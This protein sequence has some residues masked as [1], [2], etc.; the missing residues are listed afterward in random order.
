MPFTYT[1]DATFE[2]KPDDNNY[3]YEVDNYIRAL[4][5]AIRERMEVDHI[6]K[7][8]ATDGGHNKVS[9]A[10]QATKPTAVAGYGY[11]YTK[12]AGAGVIELWYEDEAGNETQITQTGSLASAFVAGVKAIFYQDTAPLGW[13]IQNTLDDKLL[14]ITKGSTAG[15]QTG[16]GVHSTGTWALSG[17]NTGSHVLT[18]AEMPA[19]THNSYAGGS[20]VIQTDAATQVAAYASTATSSTGNGGGHTHTIAGADTWRPAAYC[21]IIAAKA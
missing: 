16:G 4:Y 14:F 12:D 18:T 13:T 2:S 1:W 15:G 7:I 21:A 8:G 19:H 11:L 20:V 17:L 3:G 6:W 9:L 5:V 10:Y